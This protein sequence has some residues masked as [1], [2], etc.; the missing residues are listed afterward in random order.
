MPLVL[1]HSFVESI[2]KEKLLLNV[3]STHAQELMTYNGFRAIPHHLNFNGK[4]L[5]FS[6]N[7]NDTFF[8]NKICP[9]QFYGLNFL[10]LTFSCSNFTTQV[11]QFQCLFRL[12][13]LLGGPPNHLCFFCNCCQTHDHKY[14]PV[15][16]MHGLQV[17]IFIYS[18]QA[19]PTSN[20]QLSTVTTTGLG[21]KQLKKS[22]TQITHKKTSGQINYLTGLLRGLIS[23]QCLVMQ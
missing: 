5:S 23:A 16:R 9:A 11:Q 15:L 4:F 7:V 10:L 19:R 2:L 20:F 17:I 22:K 3:V 6:F 1:Q 14:H 12:G 18:Y 8:A 13:L 21:C